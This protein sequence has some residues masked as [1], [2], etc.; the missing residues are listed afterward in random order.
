EVWRR[1]EAQFVATDMA[2]HA[3]AARRALALQT[4]DADAADAAERSMRERGVAAPARWSSLVVGGDG[5]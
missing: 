4:G 5:P 2:L 3:M 1:A